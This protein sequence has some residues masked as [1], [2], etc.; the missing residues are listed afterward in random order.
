MT[1]KVNASKCAF[2]NKRYEEKWEKRPN[3]RIWRQIIY[4]SAYI[5]NGGQSTYG[6]ALVIELALSTTVKF[7]CECPTSNCVCS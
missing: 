6:L 1:S 3:S 2:V 5:I 7:K 4:T